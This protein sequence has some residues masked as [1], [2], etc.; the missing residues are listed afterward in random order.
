MKVA[1]V[2][3]LASAGAIGVAAANSDWGLGATLLIV[4]HCPILSRTAGQHSQ[5]PWCTTPAPLICSSPRPLLSS[6][7]T[8]LN[9][10]PYCSG[11]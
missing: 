10:W 6:A 7:R 8:R 2:T 4:P 9:C 5:L 11:S 1:V 3:A